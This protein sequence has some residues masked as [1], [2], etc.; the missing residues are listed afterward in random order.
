MAVIGLIFFTL[1]SYFSIWSYK[2]AKKKEDEGV[3]VI[4]P[5]KASIVPTALLIFGAFIC[6]LHV[7]GLWDLLVE[8]LRSH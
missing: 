6:L 8:W 2:Y 7:T 4:P 5:S 1:M 3:V